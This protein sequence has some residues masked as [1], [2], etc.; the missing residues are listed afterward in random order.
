MSARFPKTRKCQTCNEISAK[1]PRDEGKGKRVMTWC[2]S[3]CIARWLSR[4]DVQQRVDRMTRR[5]VAILLRKTLAWEAIGAR[6]DELGRGLSQA[7][8]NEVILGF[9]PDLPRAFIEGAELRCTSAANEEQGFAPLQ[10]PRAPKWRI[11][12]LDGSRRPA[13]PQVLSPCREDT[14]RLI[15]HVNQRCWDRRGEEGMTARVIVAIAEFFGADEGIAAHLKGSGAIVT[16][17]A[18]SADALRCRG[19]LLRRDR[20]SWVV[21]LRGPHVAQEHSVSSFKVDGIVMQM[22]TSTDSQ[23]VAATVAD[24]IV[25]RTEVVAGGLRTTWEIPE[26]L[27]EQGVRRFSAID[28]S[29]VSLKVKAD[30]QDP[31]DPGFT[32][33]PL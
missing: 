22:H 10:H 26:A 4:R 17:D 24:R 5:R 8:A 13:D 20:D 11:S 2:G 7:E 27:L 6:R 33:K 12:T 30:P 29:H 3:E 32:V 16:T 18:R 23:E 14:I 15:R 1:F 31:T 25:K 21:S 19:I 9:C 28:A